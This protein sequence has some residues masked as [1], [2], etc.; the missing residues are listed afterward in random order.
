MAELS[1]RICQKACNQIPF[2]MPRILLRC[3]WAEEAEEMVLT[4][5]REVVVVEAEAVVVQPEVE[6]DQ[7]A[8]K[9]RKSAS[10]ITPSGLEQVVL[11]STTIT[12]NA[13]TNISVLLVLR[14][15]E[16]ENLTRLTTALRR[17]PAAPQWGLVQW[18]PS[19]Q[20]PQVS[21]HSNMD[22]R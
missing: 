3:R 21:N 18:L 6:A 1:G 7:M 12:G 15:L 5:S 16:P 10:P 11:M 2:C 22:V 4:N 14:R 8:L 13:D 17:L 19:L 20:S 9:G